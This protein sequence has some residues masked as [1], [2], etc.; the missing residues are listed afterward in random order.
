[1]EGLKNL[2]LSSDFSL[3]TFPFNFIKLNLPSHYLPCMIM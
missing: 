1:M 3:R 2:F